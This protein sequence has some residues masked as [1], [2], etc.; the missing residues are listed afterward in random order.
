MEFE[1]IELEDLANSESPVIEITGNDPADTGKEKN[2]DDV[3]ASLADLTGGSQDDPDAM[4]ADD[5]AN[6]G[7]EDDIPGGDDNVEKKENKD[8]KDPTDKVAATSSSQNTFTSLASALFEDGSLD[9]LTDEDKEGVTDAAS[10]LELINKQ[11]KAN[12]F[13]DLNENQKEYLEAL[14]EGVP[15][16]TYASTKANADQ[17]AKIT[18]ANIT[19]R[20]DLGKELIKRSFL[21]KGFDMEKASKYAELAANGDDFQ[22]DAVDARN[23]LVAFENSRIEDEVN[24]RKQDK[25]DNEKAAE[26]ALATLKSSITDKS[27]VIPGIKINTSTREKIFKSMTT[28]TKVTDEIPLNE[29][30]DK[31]QS[32][33]EYKMRLH[34]LDVITKGFTDFSKFTTKAKSTAAQKLEKQISQGTITTGSSMNASG[35]ISASQKDINSALDNLKF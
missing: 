31:Y 1:G 3:P 29:V 2:N 9:T 8:I 5:I 13:A 27:E 28:P 11:I 25:L 10:L 17:Y 35:V 21:V 14:A 20:P 7:G 26:S 4:D 30:M 22:K 6:A 18:D 19:A 15:H 23:A 33:A 16:E 34:A 12:E 32:D 24:T